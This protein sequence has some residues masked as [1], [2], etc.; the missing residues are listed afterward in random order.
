[1]IGIPAKWLVVKSKELPPA[2][3]ALAADMLRLGAEGEFSSELRDLVYDYAGQPSAAKSQ[4]VLLMATPAEVC[5]PGQPDVRG[6]EIKPRGS[7][8]LR[9]RPEQSPPAGPSART[10]WC[11]PW[12][13]A[14]G[15]SAQ[16]A[17]RPPS[18]AT[19]ARRCPKR[20]SSAISAAPC[21][22]FRPTVRPRNGDLESQATRQSSEFGTG[23]GMPVRTG[24]LRGARRRHRRRGQQWRRRKYAPAV[25]LALSCLWRSL[26]LGGFLHSKLAAAEAKPASQ[27]GRIWSIARRRPW[28]SP[29]A[30]SRIVTCSPKRPNW[31]AERS[32]T[33]ANFPAS[34]PPRPSTRRSHWPRVWHGG[35]PRYLATACSL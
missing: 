29:A 3:P 14:R 6:G 33:I 26:A 23:M 34:R 32:N 2:D 1:M 17:G 10:R 25:A 16:T 7:D 4:T 11:F 12:P 8:G 5:R 31:R 13:R 35:D 19:F 30:F 18:S 22:R 21:C 15:M 20:Y 24:D 28:S 27:P 9:R